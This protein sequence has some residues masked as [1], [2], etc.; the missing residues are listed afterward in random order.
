MDF[1]YTINVIT[2]EIKKRKN[3]KAI[4]VRLFPYIVVISVAYS[5]LM[6]SSRLPL[7]PDPL[8]SLLGLYLHLLPVE[9]GLDAL[10]LGL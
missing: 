2:L 4:V 3:L 1:K 9:P 8:I 7:Y 10:P 6:Q 5:A